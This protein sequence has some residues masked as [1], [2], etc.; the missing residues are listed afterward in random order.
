MKFREDKE[1]K[2]MISSLKTGGV[3]LDLS[4]ANKCILMDLW[5]N[6]A[7]QEQVSIFL[8]QVYPNTRLTCYQAYCR[9]FRIGQ[10]REVEFIKVVAK[11]TIDDKMLALQKEKTKNIQQVLSLNV[12]ESRDTVKDILGF[13][14]NVTTVEGGGF[15]VELNPGK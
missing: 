2:I 1:M 4:A 14:G 12:L 13:F 15:R 10:K 8:Y 11:G 5:W 6:E 7:I 9:L 3:G